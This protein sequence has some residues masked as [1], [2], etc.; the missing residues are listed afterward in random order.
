MNSLLDSAAEFGLL[1]WFLLF[2]PVGCVLVLWL[3]WCKSR[4]IGTRATTIVVLAMAAFVFAKSISPAG[5]YADGCCKI[6]VEGDP[7]DPDE[8]Y[9]LSG[10]KAYR[11][12]DGKRYPEAFYY[13]TAEGWVWE[14]MTKRENLPGKF[15]IR[16]P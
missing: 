2:A 12:V 13:K 4:R 14:N 8:F 9:D 10:G 3:V 15:R 16:F 7:P 11:V 1:F 5:K 6:R